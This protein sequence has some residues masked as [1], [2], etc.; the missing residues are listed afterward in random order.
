MK[1]APN[2]LEPLCLASPGL[3]SD[4]TLDLRVRKFGS[5]ELQG[6]H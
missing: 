5:R 6:G 2:G 1:E 3:V 4:E